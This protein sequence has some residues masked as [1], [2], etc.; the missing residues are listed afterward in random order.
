VF[1]G[2]DSIASASFTSNNFQVSIDFGCTIAATGDTDDFEPSSFTAAQ[3]ISLH[4]ISAGLT[5][6]IIWFN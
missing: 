1:Q 3:N 4:G 5:V 6:A 2:F